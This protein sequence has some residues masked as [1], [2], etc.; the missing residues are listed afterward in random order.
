M[1]SYN[2]IV[3]KKLKTRSIEL[4]RTLVEHK[5]VQDINLRPTGNQFM[6]VFT[7]TAPKAERNKIKKLQSSKINRY[8]LIFKIRTLVNN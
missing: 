5:T 3:L 6:S 7:E 1:N 2:S 4:R 8:F